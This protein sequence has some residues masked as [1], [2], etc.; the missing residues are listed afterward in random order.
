MK[1]QLF[2]LNHFL[3]WGE[4]QNPHSKLPLFPNFKVLVFFLISWNLVFWIT[5]AWY[6]SAIHQIWRDFAQNKFSIFGLILAI[7]THLSLC[8]VTI[9]CGILLNFLRFS[10]RLQQPQL[11]VQYIKIKAIKAKNTTVA[12]KIMSTRLNSSTS[13]PYSGYIACAGL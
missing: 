8:W 3:N 4:I 7:K 11:I 13:S 6:L 9:T 2:T 12:E 10:F 1:F 5:V